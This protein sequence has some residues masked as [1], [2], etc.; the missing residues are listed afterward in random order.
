M[1]S[2]DMMYIQSFMKTG[3]GIKVILRFCLRNKKNCNF[4]VSDE[5]DL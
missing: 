2:G 1:G 3:R 4:D 5:K